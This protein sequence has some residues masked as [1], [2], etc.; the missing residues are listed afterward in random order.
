MEDINQKKYVQWVWGY[1][2]SITVMTV[3]ISRR[4]FIIGLPILAASAYLAHYGLSKFKAF[5]GNLI[6]Q[7]VVVSTLLA[8]LLAYFRGSTSPID[9]LLVLVWVVYFPIIF[10]ALKK[11]RPLEYMQNET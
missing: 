5:T 6:P 7:P 10:T 1:A 3:L 8:F 2:I 9:V 4:E 11:K